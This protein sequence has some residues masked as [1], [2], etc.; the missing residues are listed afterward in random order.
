MGETEDR[1]QKDK[2]TSDY[3]FLSDLYKYHNFMDVPYFFPS[4]QK[5]VFTN[6]L[7]IIH[8][9]KNF[10]RWWKDLTLLSYL[11][12]STQNSNQFSDHIQIITLLLAE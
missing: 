12:S 3:S 10:F 5:L 1:S 8:K 4:L 11:C 6:G 2:Q 7:L 9:G